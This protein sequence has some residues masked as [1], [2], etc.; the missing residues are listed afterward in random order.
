MSNHT[1]ELT[2]QERVTLLELINV[3]VKAAGLPAAQA[4]AHLA[5]KLQPSKE[6]PPE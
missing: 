6:A 5:E 3:A 2:E 4:A 1:V